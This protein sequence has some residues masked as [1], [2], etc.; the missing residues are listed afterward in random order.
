[1]RH[2]N[3][4]KYR[5]TA[6]AL[7]ATTMLVAPAFAQ[8]AAVP[9]VAPTAPAAT[10][11]VPADEQEIVITATK[12][13]ERLQDVPI[14]ITAITTKTLDDLQVDS[15]ADYARLVPSLSAKSGGGGGSADGPGTNN[16]YFRGVASGDNA[17]HSASLPSVGTY[18]DEQ[19]ITTI[20]GALDIHV[21]DIARVEALAGP[22]GTL[23]GASSQAGTIRI[24]TNK[25]D[26]SGTY[27]AA[28]L[29]LNSVAHGDW[30]YTGEGFVNLPL[31]TNIAARVVGWYRHDGGYID[32]IRGQRVLTENGP[33]GPTGNTLILD[34]ANLA[35][36][37]YNDVDTYG[38]RAALKIDLDDNWTIT[39][40]VIGQVQKANGSF[41]EER[42]LGD[43][44]TMQFNP[45]KL[46]DKWIQ[47]AL[48]VEGKIANLDVTYAGSYMRRQ[49]DSQLDYS[50][51]AY[52]YNELSGYGAY[53]YD[54]AGDPV[55]PNQLI[56][57]TDR[58][59]KISHELRFTTPADKRL[60][61]VAGLFYQRQEHN[62]EQN[63]IIPGLADALTVPGTNDVW[64]TKQLRVDRD[65]A[66]FG[67]LSF[68]IL[69]NLTATAGGRVYKFDNSLV[70]FFG[71]GTGYA[72]GSTGVAQCFAPA[73]V[74]G[75][76]CTNLD[77][78]VK[79]SGFVHRL[80]LTYKPNKDLLLYATWSRGF[81]PGGVN[82][83]GTFPPYAPDY[84]TNYE[85]GAKFSFGRG[86]HFNLAA[87]IEDWNAMQ[88]SLLGEN[89]LTVVRNVGK[90]RISGLEAD[91][92]LRPMQGLTWSTGVSYNHAVL[93]EDF[94][95]DELA[96]DCRDAGLFGGLDFLAEK[97]DRL[98]LTAPWKG[99]TSLRYEWN[100]N[101]DLKAHVQGLATYEG[102]RRRDLRPGIN[103][104][105][106][107]MKAYTEVDVSTGLDKGPWSLDLFVKN[108]FGVRGQL[109]R[110]IQCRE[111]VCGDPFD[112]TVNGGKIYTVVSRPR[113]IGL[114]IGRKF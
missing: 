90:S 15:F 3:L 111:E 8:D 98:P 60:R 18:L 102:K 2:T 65:Y 38:A 92:L 13:S 54:N 63:Y 46:K 48:T 7:L 80:N 27:G 84:L 76:P 53:W 24:I 9:A 100:F 93:R 114:R 97:G 35:K 74:S 96:A 77:K 47:A 49:V 17:N 16:V 88:V 62:I 71:F 86:S 56:Q 107:D 57:A 72:F 95:F 5:H 110:G 89:G 79:G 75:S 78:R 25:P 29:E 113:L 67:E 51:Y 55:V 66:A 109:S 81:R 31:T 19:P 87:Y 104:I 61:L 11:A 39:P 10:S 12:R 28:N 52:F 69:P 58:F 23:Y 45:E 1:M 37:D 6:M 4:P 105:F 64:L 106:G 40:Q 108:L 26:L 82:R 112:Q 21:F 94:C 70:G 59:K 99:S 68:D 101:P 41:A 14:A 44:Q 91:L 20:T 83:R 32:N 50:D 103:A 22:Q 73:K 42:G 30:G 34:N 33:V 43:Y 36:D 85:A